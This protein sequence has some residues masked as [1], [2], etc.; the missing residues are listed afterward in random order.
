MQDGSQ[1]YR[2]VP[3][4]TP[5]YLVEPQISA[6]TRAFYN[7]GFGRPDSIF[8]PES[9]ISQFVYDRSGRVTHSRIGTGSLA[10]ATRN[11]YDP[12]GLVTE[13]AVYVPVGGV[14]TSL[15]ATPSTT[16]RTFDALGQPIDLINP[17]GRGI[18]PTGYQARRQSWAIRDGFGNPR[19]EFPGNGSYVSRLYDWRGHVTEE[20]QSQV[21]SYQSV[22]GERFADA[23]TTTWWNSML[24]PMGKALSAGATHKYTYD[25]KG[26][27]ATTASRDMFLPDTSY[28]NHTYAYSRSGQLVV[29]TTHFTGA[30]LTRR[31]EY[32]RR[33]QRVSAVDST[34]ASGITGEKA[35]RIDYWYDSTTARLDSVVGRV[36]ATTYGRVR[37]TYDRGGREITRGARGGGGSAV[38]LVTNT[39]YDS[40]GR[41]STNT[42]GSHYS[43]TLPTYN[44]VGELLSYTS[45]EPGV[46]S[47][48]HA[49]TYATD[50]TRRL[51]SS[52]EGGMQYSYTYDF[53][54]NRL[55]ELPHQ[56]IGVSSVCENTITATFDADNR[57]LRR[58][59]GAIINNCMKTRYWTDQAGNRLGESDTT[60][61][62]PTNPPLNGLQS[63]MSYTASGQLYFSI[64]LAGD[65]FHNSYDWHWYD[66]QGRR[67]MSQ[68]ADRNLSVLYPHPDSV[69]GYR[70]YYIYDGSDVALQLVRSGSTWLVDHRFL[71]GGID[72]QLIGRFSIN[73]CLQ[74]RSPGPRPEWQRDRSG[75]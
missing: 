48:T 71:T 33:G 19:W 47:G 69:G 10:P 39:T 64:N 51:L 26:Q 16:F 35:G 37:Y 32:N 31:Y 44:K 24:M 61:S 66:A 72:Q 54:G 67:V 23:A 38:E 62:N 46:T 22:D 56:T 30:N 36:A 13:T 20:D 21:V 12:G 34:F 59:P 57:L 75:G 1:G 9:K 70:T 17:G 7:N 45:A 29:E 63:V 68:I 25:A 18:S 41:V 11:T 49:Y 5:K 50:G 65:L 15:P 60:V 58:I 40:V 52:V 2:L 43:M 42:T 55:T 53:Q 8:D 28:V 4:D 14:I 6:V 27:L 3:P 73:Q 74:E